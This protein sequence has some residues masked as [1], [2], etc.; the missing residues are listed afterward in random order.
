[1]CD[2]FDEMQFLDM[3]A[4]IKDTLRE[5]PANNNKFK[6]LPTIAKYSRFKLGSLCSQSF[7]ER[8]NSDSQNIV[9]DNRNHLEQDTI[10]K[11]ILIRMSKK[12]MEFCR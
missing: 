12:F 8:M 2:L 5:D 10:D 9:T 7:A 3:K 11:L 1:M 4:L 6:L